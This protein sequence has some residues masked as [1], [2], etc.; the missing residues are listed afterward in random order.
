M[1]VI[2][3]NTFFYIFCILLQVLRHIAFKI[4]FN[5]EQINYTPAL[6]ACAESN[7]TLYCALKPYDNYKNSI[8]FFIPLDINI[9]KKKGYPFS[10]CYK[11]HISSSQRV[12]F[13]VQRCNEYSWRKRV[14]FIFLLLIN[15]IDEKG[16]P[17]LS[18]SK[19][20][21]LSDKHRFFFEKMSGYFIFFTNTSCHQK[22]YDCVT[23]GGLYVILNVS[24]R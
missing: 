19:T 11:G 7:G 8:P 10:S 21:H 1:S 24:C 18:Y 6:K 13:F 9:L 3:L 22:G 5:D 12:S 2:L 16:Y 23:S 20:T 15:K 4:N 17:F 14:P